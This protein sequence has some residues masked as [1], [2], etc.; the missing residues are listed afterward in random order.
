MNAAIEADEDVQDTDQCRAYEGN[1]I[2]CEGDVAGTTD[3]GLPLCQHHLEKS[4]L[5]DYPRVK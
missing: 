4:D 3:D 2:P 5:Y 1:Y